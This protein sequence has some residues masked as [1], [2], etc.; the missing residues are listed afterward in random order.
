M[1]CNHSKTETKNN[2][3]EEN[4]TIHQ[5]TPHTNVKAMTTQS[6]NQGDENEHTIEMPWAWIKTTSD[7]VENF[8]DY[9]GITI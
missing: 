7:I 3:L 8:Q 9:K 6:G 4:I 5:N 1:G 2:A